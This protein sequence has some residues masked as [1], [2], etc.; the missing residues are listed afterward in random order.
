[1]QGVKHKHAGRFFELEVECLFNTFNFEY[2]Y[3]F[4]LLYVCW[5]ASVCDGSEGVRVFARRCTSKMD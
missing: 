2:S 4:G 5:F 3:Q 1:M